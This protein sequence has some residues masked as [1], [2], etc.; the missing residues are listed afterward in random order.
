[1]STLDGLSES[2]DES[3][4]TQAPVVAE[5]QRLSRRQSIVDIS[6]TCLWVLASDLLIYH[7]V[8]TLRGPRSW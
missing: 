5:T 8:V 7:S 3:A 6:T 2:R 4:L 1:M